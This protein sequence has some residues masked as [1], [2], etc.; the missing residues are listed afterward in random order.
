MSRVGELSV[1]VDCTTEFKI[2]TGFV[3]SFRGKW[4]R[5]GGWGGERERDFVIFVY[6]FLYIFFNVVNF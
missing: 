5:P 3:C 1:V 2:F 4:G 6:M